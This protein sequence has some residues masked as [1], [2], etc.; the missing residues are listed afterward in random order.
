MRNQIL[1]SCD[2]DHL[3]FFLPCTVA[4]KRKLGPG[5]ITQALGECTPMLTIWHILALMPFVTA[6]RICHV[7]GSYGL[8]E[9]KGGAAE[10]TSRSMPPTNYCMQIAGWISN[11]TTI[12]VGRRYRRNKTLK[13]SAVDQT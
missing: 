10:T 2:D 8:L 9:E 1:I 5:Q 3:E 11:N 7:E 6:R 4:A 13:K 12:S